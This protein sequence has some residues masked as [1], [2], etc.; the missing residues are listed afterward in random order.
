LDP[1]LEAALVPVLRDL[2]STC[3]VA[4]TVRDERWAEPPLITAMA[5]DPSGSGSGIHLSEGASPVEQ[6]ADLADQ[7]RDVAIESLWFAGLPVTW[8]ECP[9]HP[10]SHP[11]DPRVVS[12]RAVW[13]CPMTLEVIAEIGMLDVSNG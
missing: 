13:R 1:Q 8:P 9:Q 2:E 11:L 12:F 5:W 3:R 10:N 6:I 7:L 4:L